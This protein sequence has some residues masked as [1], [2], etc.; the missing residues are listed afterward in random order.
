V[1]YQRIETPADFAKVVVLGATP[2]TR[3]LEF[4]G[5]YRWRHCARSEQADEAARDVAQFANTEG[6][7]L[8]VGVSERDGPDGRKVADDI[9]PVTDIHGLKGWL[10]QAVRNHLDPATFSHPIIPI[11]TGR[12]AI[13]AVNVDPSLHLVALW[14]GN[15]RHG[16]EYLYRTDLG[17]AWMNPG[18]VERH[19]MN[20]S[21]AVA[22]RLK[23]VFEKANRDQPV[24]LAPPVLVFPTTVPPLPAMR[25][26]SLAPAAPVVLEGCRVIWRGMS[27]AQI[28]LSV[29]RPGS[30][31]MAAPALVIA[32]PH[33][34]VRE[35][36]VTSDRR[37]GFC[38][39]VRI[40]LAHAEDSSEYYLDP[41]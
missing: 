15:D 23:D 18:E 16:I 39:A 25:M 3:H 12:G 17:K 6:G 37:P 5:A 26:A 36:W 2:E 19:L 22:L 10:E 29:Y 1:P 20:S 32:L 11:D 41:A 27:D 28:T 7:V 24:D 13:L 21:R 35:T 30:D 8:L 14:H 33:G 38:L 31:L 9:V 4:K 34:L 40:V